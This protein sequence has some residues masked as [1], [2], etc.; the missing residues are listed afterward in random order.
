[1]PEQWDII[2]IG[3][4]AAGLAAAATLAQTRPT[5][6]TLL[7]EQA[8]RP[9]KK[10]LA[11]GNGRCNLYQM[12]LTQERFA[13][14]DTLSPAVLTPVLETDQLAFWR[15][16]GLLTLEQDEGRVYP[17]CQQAS[18]VT[19]LLSAVALQRGIALRCGQRVTALRKSAAGFALTL[20]DG[21]QYTAGRV[22]LATGGRA[23]PKL[24]ATGDGYSLAGQLGHSCTPLRPGLVPIRTVNPSK[25]L[26]GVRNTAQVSLL[27]DGNCLQSRFG[28]VQFTDYGVSGIVM[29]DLSCHMVP[30][31][32][33]TITLDLLPELS[34]GRLLGILR[35]KTHTH[36]T[37]R[38]DF[39]LLGIVKHQLGE[40]ILRASRVDGKRR[41]L[42][43]LTEGELI[44]IVQRCKGWTLRT[45][46]TLSWDHAQITCGGI[47][48]D[49]V[50][51]GTMESRLTPGLYLTGELLDLTG[52][53][54]GFNL[55]WAFGTGI[56]AGNAIVGNTP[57]LHR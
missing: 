53:C 48:L 22:I 25:V 54:G 3:A 10:L 51:P 41:P 44:T 15:R 11:T 38:A 29:M 24:G 7:L 45:E 46:G 34:T 18:A 39:L 4:G 55:S 1:M 14:I 8:D 36:P 57:T 26:R 37:Q 33:Y 40:V 5:P 43:T 6:R 56:L 27:L 13:A 31:K 9:G 21:T 49:E 28:E 19:D 47:P 20:S 2:I 52:D 23:A 30:G 12:Q 35:E 16:L 32:A 17:L 42:S 50:T